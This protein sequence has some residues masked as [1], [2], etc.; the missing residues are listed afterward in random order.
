[1]QPLNIWNRYKVYCMS[2]AG[3]QAGAGWNRGQSAME[4][5]M[6]YGWAVL[7]IAVVLVALFQL[8]AFNPY[9]FSP[10]LPPGTCTIFR[11]Y[12]INTT[13]NIEQFGICNSEL[14]QFVG[15]MSQGQH[16]NILMHVRS[17]TPS[18]TITFWMEPFNNGT[19]PQNVLYLQGGS[20]NQ[21]IYIY[22]VPDPAPPYEPW[23]FYALTVNTTS[24][25]WY[26][27]TNETVTQNG[28]TTSSHIT[29]I[30]LGGPHPAHG[31][32]AL[33]AMVADVQLYNTS[34]SR[35]A[36]NAS[37]VKGIGA[38]PSNI[39][40]LVG[41]WPLNSNV[42]DYSGNGN[43]STV[44]NVTFTTNWIYHYLPPKGRP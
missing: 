2:G 10:R 13:G 25:R 1:M 20:Y 37:Y 15:Y 24:G 35:S 40:H 19:T 39:V 43:N 7:I 26:L 17:N 6:T 16:S 21:A 28:T 5:L 22:W 23:S 32:Y 18:F 33:N 30:D 4:F 9:N 3:P 34:F 31:L 14:P 44:R 36:L 27:Y 42:F 11:P 38:D 8:G 29:S 41:W 12:G